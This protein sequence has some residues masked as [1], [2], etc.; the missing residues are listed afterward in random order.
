MRSNVSGHTTYNQNSEGMNSLSD[1]PSTSAAA[2]SN[3]NSGMSPFCVQPSLIFLKFLS[4]IDIGS[5]TQHAQLSSRLENIRVSP[6]NEQTTPSGSQAPVTIRTE[7]MTTGSDNDANSAATE[8]F[9]L[10]AEGTVQIH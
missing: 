4:D 1:E 6:H 3:R 8:N 7:N 2:Q 10:E 5:S 9:T